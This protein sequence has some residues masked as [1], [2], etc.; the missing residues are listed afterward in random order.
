MLYTRGIGGPRQ[1]KP[2]GAVGLVSWFGFNY[3]PSVLPFLLGY[4]NC[5]TALHIDVKNMFIFPNV[6]HLFAWKFSKLH[7]FLILAVGFNT[8]IEAHE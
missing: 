8:N 6:L 3:R 2:L 4:S 7:V 1:S 5:K